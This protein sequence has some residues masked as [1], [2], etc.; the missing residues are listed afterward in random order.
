MEVDLTSVHLTI[1]VV[2]KFLTFDNLI[3][4]TSQ[5]KPFLVQVPLRLL[6]FG[7]GGYFVHI[8]SP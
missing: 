3:P 5:I 8:M 6:V 7:Y 1:R 2:T 4:L